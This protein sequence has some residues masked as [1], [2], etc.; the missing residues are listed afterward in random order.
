M[1]SGVASKQQ[2]SAGKRWTVRMK[3]TT[4]AAIRKH[5]AETMAATANYLVIKPINMAQNKAE[6]Q[7]T[8]NTA[9]SKTRKGNTERTSDGGRK[10][11]SGGS[12]NTNN[13]GHKKG[14]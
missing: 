2:A 14:V 13:R 5:S 7:Q 6:K 10:A 4:A 8:S 12:T 9:N 1:K 11:A 3:N